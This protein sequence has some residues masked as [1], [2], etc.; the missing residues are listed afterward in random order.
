MV[1]TIS[2]YLIRRT[3]QL[4]FGRDKIKKYFEPLTQVLAEQLKY[5]QNKRSAMIDDFEAEF[6]SV[7]NWKK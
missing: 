4:N 2:D 5:D 6:E 3:G 1:C 7:M